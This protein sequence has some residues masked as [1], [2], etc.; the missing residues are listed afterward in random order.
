[1][2]RYIRDSLREIR[3]IF[4]RRRLTR[5]T[6]ETLIWWNFRLP[7]TTLRMSRRGS[8]SSSSITCESDF[9]WTL[10]LIDELSIE[11]DTIVDWWWWCS[12]FR[13][14]ASFSQ[15]VAKKSQRWGG[16]VPSLAGSDDTDMMWWHEKWVENRQVNSLSITWTRNI[17]SCG[18]EFRVG[19]HIFAFFYRPL[20]FDDTRLTIYWVGATAGKKCISSNLS[21]NFTTD[22]WIHIISRSLARFVAPSGSILY[23]VLWSMKPLFSN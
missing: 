7:T 6:F 9:L 10:T 17:V 23:I 12:T 4:R 1:M 5:V 22:N 21:I 2:W 15:V 13:E 16:K 3:S 8:T 20:N 18:R 14:S 19:V 11:F